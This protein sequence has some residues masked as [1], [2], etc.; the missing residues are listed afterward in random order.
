MASPTE[1][2]LWGM[3]TAKVEAAENVFLKKN[4][5]AL[6]WA[7]LGDITKLP[8]DFENLKDAMARAYP[9]RKP[10]AIPIMAGQVHPSG[11]GGRHGRIRKQAR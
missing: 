9:E 11:Q 3:H 2:T 1:P 5:I 7:E 8:S 4:Y 10:G 6:S